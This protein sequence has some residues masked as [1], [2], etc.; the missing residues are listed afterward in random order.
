MK[1]FETAPHDG[2]A[3]ALA[4]PETLCKQPGAWYDGL[5]S[6]LGICRHHY[7]KAGHAALL[8]ID[9][10]SGQ[11]DYYDFGRYHAPFGQ[12]RV[13]SSNTDQ[14]LTVKT[15]AVLSKEKRSIL[16]I[17]EILKELVHNNSCHGDG[18]IYG[19]YC[20]INFHKAFIQAR[21]MQEC[22]PLPYGPFTWKG[23]NCSRFVRTVILAGKPSLKNRF[24]LGFLHPLSPTPLGNVKNLE[25]HVSVSP[26][27]NIPDSNNAGAAGKYV[28][29]NKDELK[30]CL[31]VPETIPPGLPRPIHWLSGEGAGSWFHIKALEDDRVE[32]NRYA[33]GGEP[34]C[35]ST[36]L[37]TTQ[38][39]FN[40]EKPFK[41]EYISH[42][43]QVNLSQDNKHFLFA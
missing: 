32:V 21:I 34:E 6:T 35:Q 29:R 30:R 20:R 28:F 39:I 26:Q 7:Y 18:T 23:T 42:C 15:K 4:W 14:D 8:L 40:P 2:F 38:E 10:K 5:M 3:V 25:H 43:M 19:A 41:L 11:C 17:D 37:N 24:R 16:N 1:F 27:E 31:P 9:D 12:G 36:L 13:R 22:S 33:P